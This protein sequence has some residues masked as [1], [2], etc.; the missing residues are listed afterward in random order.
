MADLTKEGYVDR[1][2]G[3]G[4]FIRD[5][6]LVEKIQILGSFHDS[7]RRQGLDPTVMVLSSE[8]VRPAHEIAVALAL[9]GQQA[10]C[11]RRLALLDGEPLALLTAWLPPRYARGVS[12]L[13]LGAGSLYE[14]LAQVHG[15]EMTAA[16]NVVE[17]DQRRARATPSCSG[18][19]PG[20]PVLRVIGITRNQQDRP[21][22]YSDVLYRPE[23]FR[24]AIESRRPSPE[25]EL[26]S[27]LAVPGAARLIPEDHMANDVSLPSDF[28]GDGQLFVR[29]ATGLVREVSKWDAL[30]MNTLGMNVALGAI[31]LLLQAP[32]NFPGGNML[33]AIVI[34][35]LVMAFTLLWVYSEFAAA[36]PRAGGDYVFVSRALHPFVGWLLS[37]SQGLWLIFFWIGFNAWFALT[38][39]A[40]VAMTTLGAV[41]G[42]VRLDH[43]EQRPARPSTPS[44]A[45][46][47]SGG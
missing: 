22:E 36:M 23:R 5:R 41:T 10:W 29:N 4:T 17:V 46:P 31:F 40:P 27:P 24:F 15:V 9:R 32:G 1:T 37:W 34:G 45:S 35:T 26:H 3:K 38:F 19:A 20:S 43:G 18:L 11:L 6:K 16:D 13:D 8:F 2:R 33:L 44:S 30:I 28:A 7:V 39:A 14:A 12:D 25:S 42:P 47:R 21:V